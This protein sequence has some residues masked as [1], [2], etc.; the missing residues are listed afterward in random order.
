MP[1]PPPGTGGK[2]R[3]SQLGIFN[4]ALFH[5]LFRI[6]VDDMVRLSGVLVTI[7]IQVLFTV[8]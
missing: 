7:Y 6:C 3:N 2:Y 5:N 8:F 1:P 4:N